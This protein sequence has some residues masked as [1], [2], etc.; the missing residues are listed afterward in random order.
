MFVLKPFGWDEAEGNQRLAGDAGS[1]DIYLSSVLLMSSRSPTWAFI[2]FSPLRTVMFNPV[3]KTGFEK[4]ISC[5]ISY[6]PFCL[7]GYR[8]R[9]TA[10]LIFSFKRV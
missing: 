4:R 8:R 3:W 9:T 1:E 7:R 10:C 6:S 2:H 5:F